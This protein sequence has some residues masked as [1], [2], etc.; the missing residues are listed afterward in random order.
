MSKSK[1]NGS[2]GEAH[3]PADAPAKTPGSLAGSQARGA[4]S[5]LPAPFIRRPMASG[6][7]RADARA[8]LR[9]SLL[10]DLTGHR[11]RSR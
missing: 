1:L 10:R 11:I 2:A 3:R 4:T 7:I 6:S 9:I 5:R 8:S